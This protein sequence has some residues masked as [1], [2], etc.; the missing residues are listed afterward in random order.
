MEYIE[1]YYNNKQDKIT[2]ND[3]LKHIETACYNHGL[4]GLDGL[5]DCKSGVFNN[6][7]ADVGNGL[8]KPLNVLKLDNG[9]VNNK[10][11]I[12]KLKQVLLLYIYL[13]IEYD[14]P[15][16]IDNYYRFAGLG[17]NYLHIENEND[18]ALNAFRCNA[19]KIL[20][21]NDLN[22]F[23]DKMNDSKQAVANIVYG[24]VKHNVSGTIKSQEIQS[25]TKTL[26]D[27]RNNLSITDGQNTVNNSL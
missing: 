18:T 23:M 17:N 22:R 1:I 12:D 10:Y 19:L 25:T 27:I 9:N 5:N 13:C 11:D 16:L 7:L 15:L 14:R 6:I 24:N 3:I 8:F 21:E 2:T 26:A 4:N 20:K